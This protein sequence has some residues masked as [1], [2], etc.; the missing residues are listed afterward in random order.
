MGTPGGVALLGGFG[1]STTPSL[2]IGGW[3]VWPG[4]NNSTY[5]G[6]NQS[7]PWGA[8]D[9]GAD[10]NLS[11]GSQAEAVLRALPMKV[12]RFNFCFLYCFYLSLL[13]ILLLL[14]L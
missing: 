6:L 11:L 13:L 10:S 2:E 12:R 8:G 4:G 1:S 14:L 5:R 7:L 9:G 3:M